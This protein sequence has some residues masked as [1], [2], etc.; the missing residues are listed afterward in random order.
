M[1]YGPARAAV[2]SRTSTPSRNEVT[3]AQYIHTVG[4][5]DLSQ[6]RTE[7]SSGIGWLTFDNEERHNALTMTM[8][9]E[10]VAV[11]ER[12][13]ADNDVRVIVIRGAGERAFMSGADINEQG[14]EPDLFR[15]TAHHML[16]RLAA[17]DKPVVAMIRG[18]CFDGGVAVALQAD[19]RV[20]A[21]S[22][23]FSIPAA[24]I[25]IAYPWNSVAPL[26]TLVG[27]AAAADMLFT[28]RRLDVGEAREI[29]LVQRVYPGDRLRAEV[30]A[31]VGQVA[32]NAP[33]SVRASKAAIRAC[34][35]DP[36]TDEL[37]RLDELLR[38]CEQSADYQEGQLAFRERREPRFAGE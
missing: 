36:P 34:R 2:T 14:R 17:I 29:G 10:V 32:A 27:S 18:Y 13:A 15:H 25:G 6:V 26:V 4:S 12:Y 16:E 28:G 37:V 19:I 11:L 35:P 31:L 3:D 30:E 33:L 9:G 21:D 7:T 8:A 23:T 5:Q 22:S 1:Q 38:V 20:A 24:R